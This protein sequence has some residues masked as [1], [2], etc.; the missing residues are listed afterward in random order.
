MN[1]IDRRNNST[2]PVR[3]TELLVGGSVFVLLAASCFVDSEMIEDG[4]LLGAF[5]IAAVSFFIGAYGKSLS[6]KAVGRFLICMVVLAFVQL[7]DCFAAW[8]LSA[9][10]YVAF[11]LAIAVFVVA[12]CEGFLRLGSDAAMV[13]S[14]MALGSCVFKSFAGISPL[15]HDNTTS[16]IMAFVYMVGVFAF[17]AQRHNAGKRWLALDWRLVF[18]ITSSIF[19]CI[20]LELSKARTALLT[21]LIVCVMF[22]VLRY[23]VRVRGKALQVS[24][25]LIVL[26]LFAAVILYANIRQFDWYDDLN[27]YSQLL[28][29]KNIDS[30]RAGI[31]RQGFSAIEDN[32]LFGAGADMLPTDQYE[33][34]SYHSSYVQVL[35][36]NGLMGLA[37]L[38]GALYFI[39][40]VLAKHADDPAVCFGIAVFVGI[41][42]YNCFECTLLSN[43]VALG[44][45]QWFALA[46]ACQRALALREATTE[47]CR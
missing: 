40:S 25:F 21:C 10:R 18:V 20:G 9:I 12:F 28:S 17:L 24:Y 35:V 3:K 26:L 2:S 37:L 30:S 44:L 33:G 32:L 16:G 1:V 34:R 47:D 6:S 4:A 39:W 15:Y 14:C 36:Q 31:W 7:V 38:M 11:T 41:L 22:L 19:L 43:K 29:G 45:I 23:V 27:Q 13:L 46:L 8:E 42:I 5:A